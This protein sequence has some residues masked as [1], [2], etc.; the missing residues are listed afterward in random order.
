MRFIIVFLV[1]FIPISFYAQS[2]E[3]CSGHNFN[4]AKIELQKA[5]NDIKQKNYAI[6]NMKIIGDSLTAIAIAEPILFSI[7]GKQEI[8]DE[9]PY[10][11]FH[12]SDYWIIEG[13]LHYDVGGVFLIILDDRNGE[14]IKI[15]HSE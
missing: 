2:N 3:N 1:S 6:P 7:Y 9:K 4:D 11:I 5:L 10:K 8:L 14:V 12:I 15:A 13:T